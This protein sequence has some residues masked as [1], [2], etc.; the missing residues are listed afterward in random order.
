MKRF[1]NTI[2]I[3]SATVGLVSCESWLDRQPDDQLT[4][5]NMFEKKTSTFKN[6]TNVYSH[7]IPYHEVCNST[8]GGIAISASDECSV[9]YPTANDG[10]GRFYAVWNHGSMSPLYDQQAYIDDTYYK[11]YKGITDATYFMKNVQRC[12]ELTDKEIMI[13]R[14]EARFCRALFYF[15]LMRYYGPVVFTGDDVTDFNDETLKSRDRATW[16]T[17]VDW[18]SGECDL[19]AQDLPDSWGSDDLGRATKGAALALKARLLLMNARP[20]FNG[21]NGTHLYD[22]MVNKDGQKLFNTTYDASRW[23]LAADACKAVIDL[24]QYRLV[25]DVT[26]DPVVN[27]HNAFLLKNSP[28]NIFVLMTANNLRQQICPS[29]VG[30]GHGGCSI[31]QKVVD[32]FAMANGYYPFKDTE[33]ESYRNGLVMPEVDTRSGYKETGATSFVNPFFAQIPAHQKL[34]TPI[35]TMN[36]FV[37]REP[38]FYANVFWGGQSWVSQSQVKKDIQFYTKGNSGPPSQN[39]STTGYLP[40]KFTDPDLNTM[41]NQ[42]GTLAWPAIRYADILL[43]YIEALNEIDPSNPDILKYWNEIRSRAGVPEIGSG[44]GKVYS[45]IVGK[46]ELQRKYIRRER[47]VE[48]CF[49]GSRFFDINQWMIAEHENSGPVVGCNIKADNHTIGGEFWKRTSIFNCY[50]EGGYMTERTFEKKNYLL[51]FNQTEM[52]RCP[53]LTQNLGWK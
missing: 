26:A 8:S 46:K 40:L 47:A 11:Q 14:A 36:M 22:S 5:S 28:E 23:K 53:T 39:S 33:S 52:N 6:L 41:S 25:N 50:G 42:Y 3:L 38:R 12:G 13:W 32:A 9:K 29:G 48:L 21:Q 34:T 37:G 17:L 24:R 44:S 2:C 18:V 1:I 30:A 7:I 16:Q 10:N 45:E 20:L 51:P 49:E 27:I 43:M 15:D 35:N 4:S 31:T 19:A